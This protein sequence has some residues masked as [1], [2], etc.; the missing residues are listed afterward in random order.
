MVGINVNVRRWTS[1]NL[2]GRMQDKF[3]IW[4]STVYCFENVEKIRY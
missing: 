3:K 4:S 1:S 2:L